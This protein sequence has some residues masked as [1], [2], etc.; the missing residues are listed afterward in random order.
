M[1]GKLTRRALLAIAAPLLLS[2][3]AFG[4]GGLQVEYVISNNWTIKQFGSSG[5]YY[6]QFG[7]PGTGNGQFMLASGI[8]VDPNT[9]NVWVSDALLNR[10]Q[11]FDYNGN[12][13][14]QFG[15]TG[16]A[17]GKLYQPYGLTVD[18]S[19]NVWVADTGN[20]RIQEFTSA[21]A[22]VQSF[23]SLGGAPGQ[24]NVPVGISTG[25][26][27]NL[28]VS[29]TGNNRIQVFTLNGGSTPPTFFSSFGGYG[30]GNGQFKGPFSV[31][32]YPLG[33]AAGALVADP[34]N[35]R[36]QLFEQLSGPSSPFS[37]IEA[38]DSAPYTYPSPY[39]VAIDLS[40][41]FWGVDYNSNQVFKFNGATV[42]LSFGATGGSPVQL[43]HPTYIAIGIKPSS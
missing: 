9:Y 31:S 28:W 26:V 5:V 37:F 21:G 30:N 18:T 7:G 32:A 8:A 10:V 40:G 36:M 25:S 17:P 42:L 6:L 24:F 12:Y 22:F 38:I 13:V 33:G 20:N 1:A 3:L 39:G 15:S 35:Q 19:S 29:D 41:Y 27:P 2:S 16:T 4:S 34:Y 23:G 11:E 43:V 14:T